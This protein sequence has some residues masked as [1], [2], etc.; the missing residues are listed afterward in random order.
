[1][2]VRRAWV[3]GVLAAV[4][5]FAGLVG[6]V[7]AVEAVEAVSPSLQP[8]VLP[9]DHGAHPG[10]G[11]EWWYTAGTVADRHGRDFFWFATFYSASGFEL[12]R[13]NVVDLRADRI[14]LSKEYV[15]PGAP[16]AGSTALGVGGFT[17]GYQASGSLGSWA[18]DA[19]VPGSGELRLTLTPERPYVLNGPNGIVTE[20]MGVDSAYYSDQR[21]AAKGTLALGTRQSTVRGLGWFDHQWV[22]FGAN[23][24]AWHWNWF[25]CQLHDGTDMMLYQFITPAGTP[26]G[27]QGS[28]VDTHGAVTHPQTFTITPLTPTI[29]PAGAT[30][31]YPLRW[32]LDVPSAQVHMSLKARARNEFIA[33][34]NFPGLWEGP[35]V[36][37]SGNRGGCIVESTREPANF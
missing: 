9:A 23:A 10:F 12:A 36:S 32:S 11:V 8:V 20:G 6:F 2:G 5:A 35:A 21:L 7:E 22:N 15:A 31:T 33:N 19:P 29:T 1:M 18:V 26:T 14:V 37:T 4:V 13:V 27:V 30:G 28:T 34:Q 24:N 25:G 16:A 3:F 17:L